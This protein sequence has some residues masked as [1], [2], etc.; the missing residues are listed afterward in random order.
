[1]N[2]HR[3]GTSCPSAQE[4]HPARTS[5]FAAISEKKP[6]DRSCAAINVIGNASSLS[7]VH[8][9]FDLAVENSSSTVAGH[10]PV[11]VPIESK[12]VGSTE[13]QQDK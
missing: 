12:V 2:Q 3:P 7:T 8:R 9:L 1:M 10:D 4:R 6:I 5:D 11:Q 13:T